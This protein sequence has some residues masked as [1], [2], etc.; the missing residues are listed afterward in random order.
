MTETKIFS[1]GL[2]QDK[3]GRKALEGLAAKVRE[4]L[5]GKSCD[6]ALLFLSEGHSGLEPREAVRAFRGQ[7]SAGHLIGCN[8]NGVIGDRDEVEMEPAISVLA[9]HLPNVRMAPFSLSPEE[10]GRIATGADLVQELDLYPTD[11]P[12]FIILADPMSCDVT[13]LLDLFNQGYAKR[14]VVG[15]LASGGVVGAPNWLA[16]DDEIYASG[17]VGMAVAGDIEFETVVSQGCRPIGEP[18]AITKAE[19]NVLFEL[20]GK[21]ALEAF[22][23]VYEKL[24]AGDQQLAQ[25]SLFVGLARD[26]FRADMRRG[27][28]LIRNIL[29]ADRR[30]GALVIGEMLQVGQTLQFQLRDAA[31]SKE[32]LEI[33]LRR[34]VAPRRPASEGGILV[35][36]CGRGK[37]L[38][39]EPH[40]D[41]TLIQKL[42]GPFP[43]TGFFANGEFGPIDQKNYV[44]GYTS[45]LT[46]IR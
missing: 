6:L 30:S 20:A 39:G 37:G 1:S 41:V 31:T 46:L 42:R 28:F 17:A 15:G 5:G 8:A 35:S 32:D 45:S 43:L 12:G 23:Q 21:A 29:G 9:M 4:D 22:R 36:C 11:D 33:L 25:H 18:F 10:I 34:I 16:L 3:D 26:E 7:V 13:R 27:D 24:P 14:P 19:Q 40:H 2:S 38:F 44:H